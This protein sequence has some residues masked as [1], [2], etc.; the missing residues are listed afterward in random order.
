VHT[1]P[2][3][4]LKLTVGALCAAAVL[5]AGCGGNDYKDSVKSAAQ[6]FKKSVQGTS[7][8]I[9][10]ATSKQEYA[11]GV[12]KF[13]AA[14][15]QFND[16][17]SKLNPPSGAKAAQDRLISVLNTFSADLETIKNAVNKGDIE[18]VRQLQAKFAADVN[19]VQSAGKELENKAG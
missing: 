8:E 15:K 4:K 9:R 18:K 14:I 11:A 10:G 6:D 2:R 16:R 13:Q 3:Q 1:K 17:V 5:V 7:A 19:E 12:T